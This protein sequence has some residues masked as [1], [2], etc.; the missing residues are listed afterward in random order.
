MLN[1]FYGWVGKHSISLFLLA[2]CVVAGTM[3]VNLVDVVRKP[4]DSK[5]FKGGIQNHIV[6]SIKGECYFVKPYSDDTVYLVPVP[7]CDK[8]DKK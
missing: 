2:L 3:I 1:S 8:S 6:W 4:A 7:D 5:Q